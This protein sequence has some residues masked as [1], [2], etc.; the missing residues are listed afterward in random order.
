MEAGRRG[1][2][3]VALREQRLLHGWSHQY[4]A[5]AIRT[6]CEQ[7]NQPTGI[8]ADMIS[9]WERGLHTPSRFYQ[10]KLCRLFGMNAPDLGFIHLPRNELSAEISPSAHVRDRVLL[11]KACSQSI[12]L[13]PLPSREHAT[14]KDI[15]DTVGQKAEQLEMSKSRRQLLQEILRAACFSLVLPPEEL[16][17]ADS[18]ERLA[19]VVT[20]PTSIDKQILHDLETIT[21]SYWQLRTNATPSALMN[22]ALGHFQTL[23]QIMRATHSESIHAN[24]SSLISETAQ[25]IG[26]MLFDLH[27]YATAWSFYSFSLHIASQADN[28]DLEAVGLVRMSFLYTYSD[29]AQQALPLLER[30]QYLARHNATT[31]VQPW[32]A[33][34]KAEVHAHL[35]D[36]TAC[37]KVL[38][39][40]EFLTPFKEDLYATGFNISRLAGYKGVCFVR[41][42]QPD[43]ALP[44]LHEALRL[45]QP[46]SLRRQSTL[47]TDIATAHAQRGAI[48]EACTFGQ[49]ALALTSQAGSTTIFH[50]IRKLRNELEAWSDATCVKDFDERL[51]V[52]MRAFTSGGD[53]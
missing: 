38:E 9:K 39:A 14:I 5:D 4:V 28:R 50:R 46:L 12:D 42:R 31:A 17:S 7:D 3:N 22:G 11:K 10:E 40:A 51:S 8:T 29:Q 41:L 2:P 49:Q 52:T 34:V 1:Q 26:Q 18:W 44:A 27:D 19:K 37:L 20:R 24:L 45:S 47:F 53:S 16:L 25:V 33:A 6:L 32:L 48:E 15:P 13:F 21:K 23:V 30:A 36:M 35:R 43:R